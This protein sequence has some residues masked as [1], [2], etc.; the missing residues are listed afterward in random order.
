MK[1]ED[2]QV[3]HIKIQLRFVEQGRY[4]YRRPEIRLCGKWLEDCGFSC[5]K[6][7]TIKCKKGKLII[8]VR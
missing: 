8:T 5:G 3:R 7:V 6:T 1:S 2:L 4:K